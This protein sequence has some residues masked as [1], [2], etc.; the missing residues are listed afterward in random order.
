MV[1]ALL[2][3]LYTQLYSFSDNA[4]NLL[5][6]ECSMESISKIKWRVRDDSGGCEVVCVEGGWLAGMVLVGRHG[7]G[8]QAWCWLSLM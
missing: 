4:V 8:W 1:V 3:L 7:V 6:Y 2:L 5:W